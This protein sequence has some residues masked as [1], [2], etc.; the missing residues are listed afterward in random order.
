MMDLLN[1]TPEELLAVKAQLGEN[2]HAQYQKVENPLRDFASGIVAPRIDIPGSALGRLLSQSTLQVKPK[3]RKGDFRILETKD[4]AENYILIA[5][6]PL[7]CFAH[8][9]VEVKDAKGAQN[10]IIDDALFEKM[11]AVSPI[12]TAPGDFDLWQGKLSLHFFFLLYC[13]NDEAELAVEVNQPRMEKHRNYFQN[14]LNAIASMQDV[15]SFIKK[16]GQDPYAENAK[17]GDANG[18]YWCA[19]EHTQ[20]KH[21]G[22]APYVFKSTLETFRHAVVE[23]LRAKK[24]YL[25]DVNHDTVQEILGRKY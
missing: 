24:R 5:P 12:A 11:N 1:A 19:V 14:R 18:H 16:V 15:W 25:D 9:C 7:I 2:F 20:M 23:D 4:V 21:D 13:R 3:V 17:E 6:S 10:F 8:A 22:V